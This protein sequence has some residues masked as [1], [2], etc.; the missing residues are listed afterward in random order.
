MSSRS[1]VTRAPGT[2]GLPDI[3]THEGIVALGQLTT[4]G[5]TASFFAYVYSVK[6]QLY[7]LFWAAGWSLLALESLSP[8]L[9][10]FICVQPTRS[11]RVC[12]SIWVLP[13]NRL[14]RYE[15]CR[16]CS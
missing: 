4:A 13:T 1:A 2:S 11:V 10:S 15:P 14:L 5:L 16:E 9:D 12:S 6:R 8:T 7:L 3:L